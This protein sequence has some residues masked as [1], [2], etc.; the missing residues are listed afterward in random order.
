M[1]YEIYYSKVAKEDILILK[2]SEIVAY[3]KLKK[4]IAELHLHP[5]IGS[6]QPKPL[7]RDLSGYYSR[8]IDKKNRLVYKIDG[9][10]VHVLSVRGHY[11]DK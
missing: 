4:L 9:E 8:R 7:R 6:G 2:K 5:L 10:V 11:G 1:I 3:E